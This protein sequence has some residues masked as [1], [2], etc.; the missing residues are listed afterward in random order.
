[1]RK[2][3]KGKKKSEKF[4]FNSIYKNE[5]YIFALFF[6]NDTIQNIDYLFACF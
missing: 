3:K 4:L 6:G 5:Q 2:E 1:M